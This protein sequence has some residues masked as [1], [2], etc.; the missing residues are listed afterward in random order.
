[1]K[2]F[3]VV[4]H[5]HKNW[6]FIPNIRKDG[7]LIEDRCNMGKLFAAHFKQLFGQKRASRFKIDFRKLFNH[8]SQVDLIQLERPFTLEV[9]KMRCSS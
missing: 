1:M 8:K 7:A 2:I 3:Q 6:N 5:G 4:A 9:S